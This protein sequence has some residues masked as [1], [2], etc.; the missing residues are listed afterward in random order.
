METRG[1]NYPVDIEHPKLLDLLRF[2]EEKRGA[3]TMPR[4]SE[5]DVLELAPWLGN[6]ILL[7]VLDYGENFLYRVYGTN[8]V[9]LIQYDRTGKST[10][11]LK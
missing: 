10:D 7:E 3:R 2:W 5:I 11:D 6:L 9:R 4:R 8:L 1:L